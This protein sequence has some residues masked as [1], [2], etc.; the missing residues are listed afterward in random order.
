MS[1]GIVMQEQQAEGNIFAAFII[2]NI[3]QMQQ[4]RF[5]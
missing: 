1:Q 2:Q 4:R 5:Q 3:I